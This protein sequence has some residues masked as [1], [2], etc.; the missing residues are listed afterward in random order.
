MADVVTGEAVLLDVRA[1]RLPS[2]VLAFGLDLMIQLTVL[3]L[4][5]LLVIGATL[6]ADAA[7]LI[8]VS[9][10]T[11][12]GVIVGY[13]VVC[14]SLWR[15]RTVGKVA[16]GLRVVSEDGGPER[17]RQALLRGLAGFV[18]IWLLLG[19]VAIVASLL[20]QQG[21]RL[22]DVFAGTLVIR[23][24]IPVRGGTLPLMP[25]ALAGWAKGLELSRLPD[26]VALTA[27]QY[28]ARY[29]EL[30]PEVRH[31]MGRRIATTV[32]VHVSPAAPPGTHPLAYLSA[33]LAERRRREEWRLH[34]QRPPGSMPGGMGRPPVAPTGPYAPPPTAAPRRPSP[35]PGGFAPPS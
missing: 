4:L 3:Y 26:D 2:R 9:L 34:A 32:S 28:V 6:V 35:P 13:P 5:S 14:E 24:R 1:A 19:S 8:G 20:S 21:K 17:F 18:E 29:S 33:V 31:E 15:G 25:A 12:I 7:L 30:A 11:Y 16:L 23:E 10:V 22:G 27:R